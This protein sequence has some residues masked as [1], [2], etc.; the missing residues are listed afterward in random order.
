MLNIHVEVK[1]QE[2]EKL[3][4]FLKIKNSKTTGF[5]CCGHCVYFKIG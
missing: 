1:V 4:V 2:N 5:L 3:V